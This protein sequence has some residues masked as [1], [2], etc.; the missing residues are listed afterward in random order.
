VETNVLK[1]EQFYSDKI[2]T[3]EKEIENLS[4]NRITLK[5]KSLKE[6]RDFAINN[7]AKY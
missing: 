7:A 2:K 6:Q 3:L 4:E 5:M 1:D